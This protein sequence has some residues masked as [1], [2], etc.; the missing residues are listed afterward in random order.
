V[1]GAFGVIFALFL[2]WLFLKYEKRSFKEIGLTWQAG[3]VIRFL[4]GVF[5]GS[6]IFG[7]ILLALLL[8]T[9][10][11]L[12]LNN[13][14][15]GTSALIGYVAFFAISLMEE[16][17][18]RAYPFLKLQSRFGLR[19]TQII[20]AIVFALYHVAGGQSVAGSF[21]GP[22]VYAFV[23]GLAA[24]WSGGI[25][26]PFGIHLALNV[27]QPLTG[28]RGADAAIWTLKQKQAVVD[29]QLANPETVGLAMQ[30]IIL[31][32]SILLT[33]YFIRKRDNSKHMGALD[34]HREK[35]VTAR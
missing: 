28:M 24:A 34:W 9:P 7:L 21:L 1:L 14:T 11:Q 2:T 5:I 4:V 16:I 15:L 17:S 27:L 35:E 6:A 26:M 29:N 30:I 19:I 25:A 13:R 18:F 8:L 33:E 32:T 12:Q 22:G 23:F 3:T 31:V 20:V 10:L